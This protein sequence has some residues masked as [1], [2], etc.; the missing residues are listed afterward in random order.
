MK[1]GKQTHQ[2]EG[3]KNGREKEYCDEDGAADEATETSWP[4]S[5]EFV[6]INVNTYTANAVRNMYAPVSKGGGLVDISMPAD[7]ED[8]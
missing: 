5:L 2:G 1:H 3:K 7:S 8:S 4:A 6:I